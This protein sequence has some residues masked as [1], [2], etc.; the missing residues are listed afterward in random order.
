MERIATSGLTQSGIEVRW[1]HSCHQPGSGRTARTY[2]TR[3]AAARSRPAAV[4]ARSPLLALHNISGLTPAHG[5]LSG[6]RG[7]SIGPEWRVRPRIDSEITQTSL[8]GGVDVALLGGRINTAPAAN[9]RDD[10]Q[11]HDQPHHQSHPA[12]TN[13]GGI[14]GSYGSEPRGS[15]SWSMPQI[16]HGEP[17]G[18]QGSDGGS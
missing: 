5:T 7:R 14:C 1:P 16:T 8:T 10:G 12:M 2:S 11:H 3:I 13:G 18:H 6:T 17:G 9:Q 4:R 15:S